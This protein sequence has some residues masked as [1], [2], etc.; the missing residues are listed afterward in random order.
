[1]TPRSVVVATHSWSPGW[2]TALDEYLRPRAERYL[3]ISHPLFEGQ[4]RSEFRLLE[5]GRVVDSGEI[6]G[7]SGPRR[8]VADVLRTIR[9]CSKRGRFDLFVA[10]DNLLA[11]AGLWLRARRRVS[12]VALYSIDFVPRRFANPFVNSAYHFIDRT[13]VA[14]SNVVWNT[15]EGVIEGR[16][17]RDGG[18]ARSPQLVVPIGA[19]VERIAAKRVERDGGSIVYLGHLLEKQGVQVVIKALPAVLADKPRARFLVIG[20]GPYMANLV[21]LVRTLDVGKSVEFAGFIDDHSRIEQLLL[22]CAVGVAP[23]VPDES[24]Y[25][26]F[27]DLP[28]KIVTYLACGLPVITT[29]VP[30]HARHLEKAGAGRV[31]SFTAAAFTD[32]ILAYLCD[33]DALRAGRDAAVKMGLA[34]DWRRIFDGAFE[35]TARAVGAKW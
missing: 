29:T 17:E 19:E 18:R 33:T 3:W 7:T 1:V 2:A 26:R 15:G 11:M 14:K 24:N 21:Q 32:A 9:W 12:A 20:D 34:F 8:Y 5:K 22:G 27:Q 31:V 6:A 4:G 30:R 25:S 28:G 10:G 35:Q 16:Q 13:A 23:Y